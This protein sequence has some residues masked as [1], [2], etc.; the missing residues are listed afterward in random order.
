MVNKN[1]WVGKR[2]LRSFLFGAFV[3]VFFIGIVLAYYHMVYEEKRN[4][5]IKD[6]RIAA[7]QSANEFDNYIS[8]N[9]DLINFAAYTLDEMIVEGKSDEEIQDYLVSQSVAV[10]SAVLEN[11]TG[12]YAYINGRFFSGT[13]WVPPEGYDAV[14]RP[15]YIK[16]MGNPGVVTILEPYL[17]VQSGNT[18]LALGKT[19]CDG[20]S[21][22][23]V[24]V[25]LE[26]VQ[27]LTEDA[28]LSENADI[29][30][31]LTDEGI[32]VTHSDIN[33]VGKNYSVDDGS[34][35]AELM[36][37]I[38]KRDDGYFEF[39][40]NGLYYIVYS[41]N[42]QNGWH[43]ISVHDATKA[44]DSLNIFFVLTIVVIIVMVSIIV[45]LVAISNRRGVMAERAVAAS[46]AKSSFLSNMS[47]EIRT[48]LNA[49]IG[50]NEMILRESDDQNILAY[51]KNV[52]ASG[53]TLLS[54]VNDILDFSR[55]EAGK[56]EIINVDYDLSSLL[57]DL[58]NMVRTRANDKGL[59]LILDFDKETPKRLNGD[60]VRIKQIIT[61]LLTNAVKFTEK[62]SITFRLN[63]QKDEEDDESVLLSV[64][65]EDT[66]IG[67]KEEDMDKLFFEF[68]RIEEKRNRS[69]EGT[70]LGMNITENLLSM[71]GSSLKIESVYGE[72]SRFSFKLKQ[73][74][75][76]WESLGDYEE[77]SRK[78]SKSKEKYHESFKA[79]EARVLICDDNPMNLVVIQ[80]LMKHT[81]VIV[82]TV[83]S[84]AEAIKKADEKVYDII[85]LDHMMPEKDGIETL[86]EL[87]ENKEGLN[88]KTPKIC[89]TANAVSGSRQRYLSE[90]FDD[91]L[92]KPV[93][94][95][96][97]EKM[98]L[99]Y[100]PS[101]LV[102]KVEYKEDD[103]DINDDEL[104][105][106]LKKISSDGSINAKTGLQNS[107]SL[108]AYMSLLKIFYNSIDEIANGIEEHYKNKDW[109]NYTIKVHALKSSARIIG[110]TDLGEEAQRLEN[111]GK[112][113]NMLYLKENNSKF[114]D[115]YKSFKALLEPLFSND[116]EDDDKPL[117]DDSLMKDLYVRLK[118]A[119]KDMDCD[120]LQDIFM[121]TE[122]YRIPDSEK[123]L[124]IKLKNASDNFN[125]ELVI[126]LLSDVEN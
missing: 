44:F 91:Y 73:K 102:E 92:T 83:G 58:V 5:I 29:E 62:G 126:S 77:A 122:G 123:E 67:I 101:E 124:W 37:R 89:L 2:T 95:K 75:K 53:N 26:R 94:T 19:L 64:A 42:F 63:Y 74:V 100:L 120:R 9:I 36:K 57:N 88:C 13:N 118:S 99:K 115:T 104:T 65:V 117:A 33:E 112:S 80:N 108:D 107:G 1:N 93:D 10:K 41:A 81:E 48:P 35:G 32:V 116:E 47:H 69:I 76:S 85:F 3:I 18:M 79:P 68:E 21:V 86:H 52:K 105:D 49:V 82:D 16:P 109:K 66:G 71:M 27:N 15:W 14:S 119:A 38:S 30:M 111:A 40:Y 84:G 60:E 78:I 55:I 45:I 98:M 61:N 7:I 6:G 11:Y 90:G 23:S 12:L 24:D 4:N 87:C 54:I 96:K 22:I 70:G 59:S 125:Y 43:C 50:M 113:D 17:D 103:D 20:K 121:E 46:E 39:K 97:L 31:I 110:A 8:T 25:S 34:F 114:L 72:G 28:V 106:E 51:A 56:L